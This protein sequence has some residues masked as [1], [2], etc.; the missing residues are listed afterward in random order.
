[1]SETNNE[2]SGS[3]EIAYDLLKSMLNHISDEKVCKDPQLSSSKIKQEKGTP[4]ELGWQCAT[5]GETWKIT[6]HRLRNTLSDPRIREFGRY[7]WT[8]YYRKIEKMMSK[9]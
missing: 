9:G 2:V 8:D 4:Q 1:M 6:V 5:C 7:P 3:Y